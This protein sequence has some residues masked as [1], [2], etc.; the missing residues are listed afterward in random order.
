VAQITIDL[1]EIRGFGLPDVVVLC[2]LVAFVAGLAVLGRSWG[3]PFVAE[4]PIDLGNWSLV[5]YSLLSMTRGLLA[6]LVSFGLSL[7]WGLWAAKS[8]RAERVLLPLVDILQSIPVLGF[9]PALVMAMVGLFPSNRVGLELTAVLLLVSSQAWNMVLAFY[10]SCTSIPRDLSDAADASGLRGWRRFVS[11]ELPAGSRGLVWNGMLSMAGGWF[12]LV[13]IESFQVGRQGFRLPGLGSYMATAIEAGDVSA[14]LRAL[15]AM[16]VIVVAVD[17]LA[18]RP[19]LALAWRFR[20]AEGDED[21]VSSWFGDLLTRMLRGK[22]LTESVA[23]R[24]WNLVRRR[25]APVVAPLRAGGRKVLLPKRLETAALFLGA[26]LLGWGGWRLA[27]LLGQ[28]AWTDWRALLLQAAETLL[29]ILAATALASLVALPL[30]VELGLSRRTSRWAR[31]FIQIVASFPAPMLFPAL[32]VVLTALGVGLN[33]GAVALMV[34]A[35]F[36]TILF[37]T[38]DGAAAIPGDLREAWAAYGVR[39]TGRWR[40][41]LLPSLLP[42]LLVAWE[43]ALVA[44]WNASIVTEYVHLHGATLTADGLGSTINQAT[45]AGNFPLLTAAV[46]VLVAVVLAT[47]RL[48]WHRLFDVA[49]R[50]Q[51]RS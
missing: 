44:G 13:A 14:M 3:A 11:L 24:A 38:I 37:H 25:G 27:T 16:A 48:I 47:N 42:N 15:A 46:L 17:Q 35:T 6:I 30:G 29:R 23:R 41:F 12:F 39:G 1:D 26:L 19:L 40:R 4:A 33:L 43:T 21:P 5:G 36:W 18:W 51:D 9:M 34:T 45:E 10:K 2:L 31:P 50:L 8:R 7:W 20:I 49:H 22:R 32:V 28:V